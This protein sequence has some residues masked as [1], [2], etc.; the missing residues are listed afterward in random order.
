[1]N[2]V[3]AH[4]WLPTMSW[5]ALAG[6]SVPIGQSGDIYIGQECTFLQEEFMHVFGG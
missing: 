4:P 3:F 2:T 5:E 6:K 1:M